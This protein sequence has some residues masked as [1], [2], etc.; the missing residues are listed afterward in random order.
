MSGNFLEVF[1]LEKKKAIK[2]KQE[3]DLFFE[4][5]NFSCVEVYQMIKETKS[6]FLEHDLGWDDRL[7]KEHEIVD[8]FFG[9]NQDLIGLFKINENLPVIEESP[10]SNLLVIFFCELM[11]GRVFYVFSMTELLLID[12]Y[13]EKVLNFVQSQ[14]LTLDI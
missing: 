10:Q 3:L 9:S 7:L 8:L 11:R 5:L 12:K 14:S 4:R 13:N 2:R 1:K 6:D